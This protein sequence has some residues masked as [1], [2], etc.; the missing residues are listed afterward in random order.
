MAVAALRAEGGVDAG[1]SEKQFLPGLLGFFR[2]SGRAGLSVKQLLADRDGCFARCVGQKSVVAD[3]HESG[4]QEMK[5]EPSK[6]FTYR[7]GHELELVPVGT[8]VPSE[9]HLAVFYRLETVVGKGDPVR[10]AREVAEDLFR[11]GEGGFAV[12]DPVLACGASKKGMALGRGRA[13]RAGIESLLEF[14]EELASEDP[15]EDPDGEQESRL[16]RDPTVAL[17]VE[18]SAGDDAVKVWVIG[19]GLGPG[20]EDRGEAD[21]GPQ[22]LGA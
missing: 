18:A 6:E 16:G 4:W 1:E 10:I 7:Q 13:E 3:A 19:E 5:Q 14:L 9:A 11:T 22:V 21:A 12:D 8:V 20:M 2:W 17:G 15:R